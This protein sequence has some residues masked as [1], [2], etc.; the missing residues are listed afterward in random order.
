MIAR[1]RLWVAPVALA[2]LAGCAG[3]PDSGGVREVDGSRIEEQPL[4]RIDPAG[5][6]TDDRPGEVVMGFVAA[7]RACPVCTDKAT[8]FLTE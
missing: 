2:L 3:I 4:N 7:M 1:R 6:A 8:Q 5:A